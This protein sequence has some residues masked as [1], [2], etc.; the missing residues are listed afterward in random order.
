MT[1][2]TEKSKNIQDMKNSSHEI[3]GETEDSKIYMG[4]ITKIKT[5]GAFVKL[6]NGLT[7]LRENE[8]PLPPSGE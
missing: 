2:P 5:F 4:E 7:G 8:D 6:D 1:Q 3:L